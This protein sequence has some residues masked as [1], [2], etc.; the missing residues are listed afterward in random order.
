VG[1]DDGREPENSDRA[2]LYG[3]NSAQFSPDSQKIVSSS[4]DKT[5]RVWSAASGSCEQTMTG[6]TVW[7]CSVAFRPDAGNCIGER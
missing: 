2:H 1:R 3:V 4:A 6:H 7:V 5:V